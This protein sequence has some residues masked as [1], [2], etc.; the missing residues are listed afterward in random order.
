MAYSMRC[1]DAD[2]SCPDAFTTETAAE[3]MKH[4]RSTPPK[5]TPASC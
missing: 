3:V 2:A 1:A 4:A 5:P